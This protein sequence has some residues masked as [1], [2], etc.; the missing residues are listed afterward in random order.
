M[1]RLRFTY[2]PPGEREERIVYSN[3]FPGRINPGQLWRPYDL[4]LQGI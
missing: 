2:T 1:L 3:E 4:I